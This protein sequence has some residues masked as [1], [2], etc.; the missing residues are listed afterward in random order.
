M[1]GEDIASAH[2]RNERK[3]KSFHDARASRLHKPP[4]HTRRALVRH[5]QRPLFF[6][7]YTPVMQTG[8]SRP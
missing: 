2:S 7:I 3:E 4:L 1:S 6:K 5:P 8:W